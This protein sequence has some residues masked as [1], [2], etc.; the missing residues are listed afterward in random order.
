M[1]CHPPAN[2]LGPERTRDELIPF[3]SESVD[4]EDEV[5]Q[6]LAENLGKLVPMVRAMCVWEGGGGGCQP[7]PPATDAARLCA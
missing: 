7:I 1:C 2:A 4:D 6:M 3:L 5:L